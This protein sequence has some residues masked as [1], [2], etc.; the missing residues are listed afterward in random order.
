VNKACLISAAA[1]TLTLSPV[2]LAADPPPL[3]VGA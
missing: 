1:A 2:A 3:D